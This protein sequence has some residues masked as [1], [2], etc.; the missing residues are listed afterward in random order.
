MKAEFICFALIFALML[1]TSTAVPFA[2]KSRTRRDAPP[3]GCKSWWRIR[4]GSTCWESARICGID[5]NTLYR[6]NG[7]LEGG[8]A[9]NYLK[10]GNFLCCEY[11]TK[12]S[13]EYNYG[14]SYGV[15]GGW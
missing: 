8:R 5:L 1:D 4:Q 12:E 6:Y 15:Y 14:Y 11:G 13:E 3:Y 2:G 9:C 10:I 7:V